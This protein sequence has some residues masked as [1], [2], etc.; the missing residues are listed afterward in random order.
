MNKTDRTEFEI[1][2]EYRID[3]DL[4]VVWDCLADSEI[5]GFWQG[6]DCVIG[7]KEGDKID[8]FGGWVTGNI[9]S[10]KEKQEISYTW[11]VIE[12]DKQT[13]PSIVQYQLREGKENQTIVT[14]SHTHLPTL[15]EQNS[16]DTGWD[17]QFFNPI[18]SYLEKA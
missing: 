18:R 10:R 9:I 5:S 6:E 1:H 3:A 14:L 2:K 7:D 4:A 8:L 15:E 12:W 16:H 13:P 17:D 11:K